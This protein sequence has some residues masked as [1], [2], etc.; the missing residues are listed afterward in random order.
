MPYTIRDGAGIKVEYSATLG[1]AGPW[2]VVP[3]FTGTVTLPGGQ[4][5]TWDATTHD[6]IIA[7]QVTKQKRAAISDIPDLGGPI[8]WDP[9]DTV[10]QALL[11]AMGARTTLEFRFT[12]FGLA[13]PK[14]GARAQVAVSNIQAN[15]EGGLTA[16]LN[17]I[18]QL[19]NFN[20]A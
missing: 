4:V 3:G 9:L 7:G 2:T 6:A 19:T 14:Y 12:V 1:W 17:I 11:V 5:A 15:M 18:A 20:V 16:Q 8:L 10:H 13:S